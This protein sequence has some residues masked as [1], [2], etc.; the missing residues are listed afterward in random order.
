LFQFLTPV[1]KIHTVA[2][3]GKKGGVL[4]FAGINY[5][6]VLIG[7][8]AAFI[9][10]S[11]WYMS[12]SASYAAALGKTA[13]QMAT[14]RKKPGA[15]LQYICAFVANLVIGWMLAGLLGHLGAG[16]VTFSNGVISA[17][18]IWFGFV[19]TTM[20]VNFTF[21]GRDKRLLAIDAGNWLIVFLV[22]GGVIGALGL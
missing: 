19:L 21:S 6:A 3:L 16:Q 2:A 1:Y 7:A 8:V 14:E 10:S 11:A 4:T 18:F 12:L 20:T 22:I 9:A 13:E 17:A 15:F 5:L